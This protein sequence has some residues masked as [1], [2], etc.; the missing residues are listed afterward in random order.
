MGMFSKRYIPHC[1]FVYLDKNGKYKT[2]I[3]KCDEDQIIKDYGNI[4]IFKRKIDEG[5]LFESDIKSYQISQKKHEYYICEFKPIKNERYDK[6]V[7]VIKN[8]Q[9][10]FFKIKHI[11]SFCGIGEGRVYIEEGRWNTSIE[12][13]R[14]T[15]DKDGFLTDN[16]KYI[17]KKFEKKN[18]L[19]KYCKL[20]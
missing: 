2:K 7:K 20:G 3:I 4:Q 6:F 5:L 18:K 15:L 17:F 10:Y 13:K 14:K 9:K 11:D 16:P 19:F 8:E 1:C 12:G